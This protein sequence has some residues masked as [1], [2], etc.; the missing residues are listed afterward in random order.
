MKFPE[1]LK[2][3]RMKEG[4][5]KAEFSRIL[6]IPYTTYNNYESGT[7][8]PKL[9]L[10][11]KISKLLNVSTDCLLGNTPHD[12]NED[13]FLLI[14]KILSKFGFKID[15]IDSKKNTITMHI[16]L[17]APNKDKSFTKET[18]AKDELITKLL[19]C[20]E[21]AKKDQNE[22]LYLKIRSTI[23]DLVS[24]NILRNYGN[25]KEDSDVIK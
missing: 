4:F 22:F 14:Q 1:N 15:N 19:T 9:E 3:Y 18:F 25:I 10:L 6:D 5:K 13:A 8:E 21:D 23:F 7:G 16:P 2:K 24:Q 12:D 20:I 11:V 17:M